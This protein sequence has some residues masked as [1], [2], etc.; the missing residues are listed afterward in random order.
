MRDR[1][2]SDKWPKQPYRGLNYYDEQDSALFIGRDVEI[3]ECAEKFSAHSVKILILQGSS[4]AGKSSFLRAGL[5]P[6]LKANPDERVEFI[7]GEENVIRC[8]NIPLYWISKAV[9]KKI[10]ER[11]LLLDEHLSA[12]KRQQLTD[13]CIR[14]ESG[15]PATYDQQGNELLT[16]LSSIS[17]ITCG[18]LTLVID[19][20]EEILTNV[21]NDS[22]LSKSD[23]AFFRFLQDI[24]ILNI[25]VKVIIA[26]RTEY[27]GRFCDEFDVNDD[28]RVISFLLRPLRSRSGLTEIIEFPAN[29]AINSDGTLHYGFSFSHEAAEKIVD[30]LLKYLQHGAVT[31][32]LQLV[33][34]DLYQTNM[35]CKEITSSDYQAGQLSTLGMKYLRIAIS[36]A[37]DLPKEHGIVTRWHHVLCHLVNK[38]GGGTVVSGIATLAI[39]KEKATEAG[40]AGDIAPVLERMCDSEYPILRG[41]PIQNPTQFSLK[42]D[43]LSIFLERWKLLHEASVRM[44]KKSQLRWIAGGISG[45]A[46]LAVAYANIDRIARS[47]LRDAATQVRIN[48][49]KNAPGSDFSQSLLWLVANID[50]AG[51]DNKL[52]AAS[53]LALKDIVQRSPWFA[54]RFRAVG[55][56]KDGKSILLLSDTERT[57]SEIG[58]GPDG[59]VVKSTLIYKKNDDR[60]NWIPSVG[61]LDNLGPAVFDEGMLHYWKNGQVNSIPVSAN[62]REEIKLLRVPRAE[63]TGGALRFL[64]VGEGKGEAKIQGILL[65]PQ[66][67]APEL[68]GKLELIAMVPDFTP[69]PLYADG[70]SQVYA[71]YQKR[72]DGRTSELVVQKPG[73]KPIATGQISVTAG[74][75]VNA[76]R[77]SFTFSF[78]A[79]DDS[80]LILKQERSGISIQ[81][82]NGTK[83][84]T[85]PLT[86]ANNGNW[87]DGAHTDFSALAEPYTDWSYSYIAAVTADG[88]ARIG[89]PASNGLWLA[90]TVAPDSTEL[91]PINNLLG[92][93]LTGESGG[94]RLQFSIDGK[95]LTLQQQ[96]L[97]NRPMQVRIFNL[98]REWQ[99][100]ISS[101]SDQK[102]LKVACEIAKFHPDA[103][104][105]ARAIAMLSKSAV[106]K[107]GI[108][109]PI[110]CEST[111]K[112]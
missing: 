96:P 7:C 9:E 58:M 48:F 23:H 52:K 37:V 85:T 2:I 39:L 11:G 34:A 70:K 5:I 99:D 13:F 104:I 92:P 107:P 112:E 91:R 28:R 54:G 63:I 72:S 10:K 68:S 12:D 55:Y 109:E 77:K 40:I 44:R 76:N 19:Q 95:F 108:K 3:Q 93:M 35:G 97:F 61:Y 78:F 101:M 103:N 102:L 30:D 69:F 26:L 79:N 49:A 45:I 57:V 64:A 53:Y 17:S 32:L 4:G 60:M 84:S 8:T 74:G 33:C 71:Y 50:G 41:Q 59:A 42:H 6:S 82:I 36:K 1:I 27:Y 47:E 65:N 31:P 66:A 73:S 90:Q 62:L 75:A 80:K 15:P 94:S 88:N 29:R 81:S 38:Q 20:A 86:L 105:N 16:A 67:S 14:L 22:K 56:S 43:V 100:A 89:W 83:V 46:L 18:T 87:S 51:N 24:Y 106:T 25:D 111:L 98:S 110:P 21:S